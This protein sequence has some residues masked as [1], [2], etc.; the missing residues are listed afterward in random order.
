MQGVPNG[1]SKDSLGA[2]ADKLQLTTK[3]AM[4]AYEWETLDYR[5]LKLTKAIKFL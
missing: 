2:H 3:G 4:L 5:I 1:V